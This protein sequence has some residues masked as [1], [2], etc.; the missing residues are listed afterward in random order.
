M[1]INPSDLGLEALKSDAARLLDSAKMHI[2][3]MVEREIV[4]DKQTTTVKALVDYY[5]T[6][7]K[8]PH[9]C[10][11]ILKLLDVSSTDELRN[12]IIACNE[13]LERNE[14][15]YKRYLDRVEH[16]YSKCKDLPEAKDI[17]KHY[18]AKV[19]SSKESKN[20]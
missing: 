9:L 4:I 6:A 20:D 16:L 15:A 7:V 2:K 3:N 11:D 10:N 1:V 18:I 8:N 17:F 14:G 12:R 5:N 13:E 19:N